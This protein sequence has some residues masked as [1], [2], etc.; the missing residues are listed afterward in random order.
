[1]KRKKFLPGRGFSVKEVDSEDERVI[2]KA[3]K[4]RE[5]IRLKLRE[6]KEVGKTNGFVKTKERKQ[7]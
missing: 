1:M 3:Q 4:E 6:M 5:L 2:Y 7:A